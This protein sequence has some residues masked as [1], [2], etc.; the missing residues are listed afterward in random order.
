[1]IQVDKVDEVFVKVQCDDSTAKELSSF[2][3]FK[4]PNHQFTPA[5]RK[6]RWD[7]KIRLFNLA[8]RT[9]YA[10]LIDYIVKFSQDRFYPITITNDTKVKFNKEDIL[11]W[12]NDQKIYSNGKQIIP[13]SYQIDAVVNAIVSNRILLLSPT[14]SGKS[15][16]IYLAIR[17]LLEHTE[18]QKFLIVV[19]TTGLVTQLASD[20]VDYCNRDKNILR[21]IHTLFQGKEKSTTKQ[22]VISTWQSI[23]REKEDFFKDFYGVVGDECHLYKA[24]S[25]VSIMRK[26]KNAPFRIGTTGTLDGTQAHKLIIEGLFGRCHAVT[27]TKELIDDKV[28]S[29]LTINSILLSYT[30]KEIQSIKKAT[31]IQEME[32]LITNQK[33]NQFISDLANSIP[34]NVLV[35]FNFVDKHGVPLHSMI[36]SAN[37]KETFMIYGKTDIEEREQIRK[38]VDKHTNSVLVASYGTC[39]TGINIKNINAIIFASPSK[40]VVRILQSIGRGLRKSEVKDSVVVFDIGDDLRYKSHRNHTLK[41]MDERLQIYTNESFTYNIKN[42]RLKEHP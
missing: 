40:S 2:F 14:G 9:T 7:G 36:Q 16:I 5:F 11:A 21:Q 4:V 13:H 33:R 15:L 30:D 19:P 10:G 22:I 20:F 31:Y 29:N 39:S 32:W 3:T 1:M 41:H 23:F 38:I 28:L 35:L 12:I 34:G 27:T 26:L 25:L 8:S 24:K 17:F 18:N 6:K 42:I 37:K